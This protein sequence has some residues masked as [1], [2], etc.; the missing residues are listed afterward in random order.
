MI[1][2]LSKSI[3]SSI[4]CDK[5]ALQVFSLFQHFIEQM[6]YVGQNEVTKQIQIMRGRGRYAPVLVAGALLDELGL[7]TTSWRPL[8]QRG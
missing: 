5:H 6:M 1:F 8:P 7:S 3:T 4:T 2:I